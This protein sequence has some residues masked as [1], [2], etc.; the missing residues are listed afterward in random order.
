MVNTSS[1]S[2]STATSRKR[3][4]TG[5]EEHDLIN[6]VRVVCEC[7]DICGLWTSWTETNPGRR[8]IGCPNYRGRNK[9]NF[10]H[11][12]DPDRNV[13]LYKG[14]IVE[15]K[16]EVVQNRRQMMKLDEE[17]KMLKKNRLYLCYICVMVGMILTLV[18]KN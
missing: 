18:M 11:W 2:T 1:S 12:W 10:F 6:R 16:N 7:G 13:E 17:M 5:W 3:S 14:K 4:N 9:C 15:L 8:F